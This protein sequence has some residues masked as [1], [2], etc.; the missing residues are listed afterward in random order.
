MLGEVSDNVREIIGN[1]LLERLWKE[2]HTAKGAKD[3]VKIA[4]EKEVTK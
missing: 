4:D 1:G 2:R 3:T